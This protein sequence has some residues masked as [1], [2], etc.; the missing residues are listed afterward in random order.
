RAPLRDEMLRILD[1]GE[2]TFATELRCVH[3]QAYDVW[4]SLNGSI[5]TAKPPLSHCLIL[6]LQDI[7]GR[8]QA[9]AR[10]QHI[11][12]HDNLTDLANRNYFTEQLTR[13]IATVRRHRDRRFGVLFF[14]L[15]RFKLVND[16]LGHNAGDALLIE[17]ARRMRA[18]LRPKDLIARL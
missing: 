5:F 15:D 17:L 13:A 4:V 11:A 16:S 10:L 3:S 1:G 8:R 7:T 6:Q 2:T 14:D 12:Y 18:F 9:E